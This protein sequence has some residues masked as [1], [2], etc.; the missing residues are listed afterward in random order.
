M[1]ITDFRGPPFSNLPGKAEPLNDITKRMQQQHKNKREICKNK[2]I[3]EVWANF[4][5][6]IQNDVH[7]CIMLTCKQLTSF[8]QLASATV[9]SRNDL[10]TGQQSTSL[11]YFTPLAVYYQSRTHI[12]DAQTV[13]T[14]HVAS[15]RFAE[16][17]KAKNMYRVIHKNVSTRKSLI[18]RVVEVGAVWTDQHQKT[19]EIQ[20]HPCEY[21]SHQYPTDVATKR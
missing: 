15:Y 17:T 19:N 3:P 21:Q 13:G 18:T 11:A 14:L 12:L 6:F 16:I 5:H 9:Q 2:G 8:I 7:V 4:T 10:F 1:E 20:Y